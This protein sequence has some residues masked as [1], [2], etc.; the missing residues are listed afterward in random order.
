[1]TNKGC[2][3]KSVFMNY[4]LT[5]LACSKKYERFFADLWQNWLPTNNMPLETACTPVGPRKSWYNGPLLMTN[6][7]FWHLLM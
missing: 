4:E 7:M 1:L 3:L 6:D 2:L 5:L